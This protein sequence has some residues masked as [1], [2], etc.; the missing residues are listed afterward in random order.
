MDFSEGPDSR[1]NT[2][3]LIMLMPYQHEDI[4]APAAS[5]YNLASLF[6][7]VFTA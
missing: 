6:T 3:T 5:W 7:A 2:E 1:P 4:H